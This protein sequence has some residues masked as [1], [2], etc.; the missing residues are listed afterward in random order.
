MTNSERRLRKQRGAALTVGGLL[1]CLGASLGVIPSPALAQAP[2][3]AAG[4]PSATTGQTGQ[5]TAAQQAEYQREAAARGDGSQGASGFGKVLASG[6]W[7]NGLTPAEKTD[8]QA[9]RTAQLKQ[10]MTL[11][12]LD[13]ADAALQA[14]AVKRAPPGDAA[15]QTQMLL[16]LK[17]NRIL[18]YQFGVSGSAA[19]GGP[20]AQYRLL[21]HDLLPNAQLGKTRIDADWDMEINK[22]IEMLKSG[23]SYQQVADAEAKLDADLKTQAALRAPSDPAAATQLYQQLK[24]EQLV[25]D[26]WQQTP[27]SEH[28]QMLLEAVQSE[29]GGKLTPLQMEAEAVKRMALMN[30]GMRYEQASTTQVSKALQT[31]YQQ[32]ALL[33]GDGSQPVGR[34]GKIPPPILAPGSWH[35]GLSS[36]EQVDEQSRRLALLNQGKTLADL[37][38]AD[39]ALQAEAIKRA[40]PG[41]EAAQAQILLQ[42]KR[43]QI[44]GYDLS[45]NSNVPPATGGPSAQYKLL[46]HDLLPNAQ[47][48]KTRIDADWDMEINKRIEM[49]KSGMSYQQVADAEAKLDADLKT[50]AALRAPSDPAA[51]LQIYQ[52]LKH[53]QL[54]QDRWQQTPPSEHYQML[55]EAVQSESGGK[56]TPLQMEAEAVKRMALMNS[57]MRYEQASTTQVSKALQTEYQQEALLRGDGSQPVGRFGKIPPP[58]L[59]PGSWHTGLSSSEQVDEQSRRLALL[60]QGK[61]L[62]DLDQADAALQAEAIKRAP[63][64]D[65]AAQAQILLQLKRNQILGYDLSLNSNVPPATGGPS[66]QYKLLLHDLLPNAQLGKTRIDADWD[67]E[68]NKRIEMLKS[69][70]S[71]QQVADAEA[72]LDADLKTQAALRAPNDPAA[73]TQIYQQLKHQQLVQYLWEHLSP[74][75]HYQM[76]LEAIAKEPPANLTPLQIE[77]EAVK[78]MAMMNAGMNYQ[79][80]M[81]AA[82]AQR[83]LL[84]AQQMKA[85]AVAMLA[86]N[87]GKHTAT[88]QAP[89]PPSPTVTPTAPGSSR[90]ILCN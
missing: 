19:T 31:E 40:P 42:L 89:A 63:P 38:Q 11:V 47:L 90:I 43:N 48:G 34:F 72:K 14:E 3:S 58:I 46:L 45:L 50:Q 23:M 32:E 53:E 28:Y 35:T 80:V 37:D 4:T 33:R 74:D 54:V 78:R 55:L 67:M 2:A 17:R 9:R 8:E 1:A 6:P 56:L 79:D 62:A 21:L 15:A 49:L 39:A 44:L 61:T 51:A 87:Q 5:T 12:D 29:S 52:Q 10:G 27:P 86:Q 36:S 64:G 20:G 88:A 59:A 75:Q 22:R 30:S 71:Y 68:I 66:A 76:L 70:M 25:Q 65:A 82:E 85:L 41:D 77:T 73:A 13:R 16:Q 24:H 60:N 83:K 84:I 7:A 69:G 57:G 81:V 26:R 18:D